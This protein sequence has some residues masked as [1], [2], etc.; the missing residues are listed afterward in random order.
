MF[1]KFVLYGFGAIG[2]Y[3]GVKYYT[4]FARDTS[5]LSRG[6]SGLIKSFQ[7]R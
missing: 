6:G 7:G 1:R 3:L 4:G 2:L 5:A